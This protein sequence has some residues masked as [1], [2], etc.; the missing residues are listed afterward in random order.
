MKIRFEVTIEDMIAFNRYHVLNSSS[1]WPTVILGMTLVSILPLSLMLVLIL[2]RRVSLIA[3]LMIGLLVAGW[4]AFTYY[5]KFPAAIEKS[6][7]RFLKQGNNQ[8]LFGTHE[9]EIEDEWLVERTDVNASRQ[10]WKAIERIVETDEYVFIYLSAVSAHV[11]PKP[12]VTS[13]DLAAFVT[14]VKEKVAGDFSV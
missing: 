1:Y 11:I 8:G 7:R 12:A 13:G 10:A 2:S 9:L 6:T 5:R 3:S 14:R 4:A